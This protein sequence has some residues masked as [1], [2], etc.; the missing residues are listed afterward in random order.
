M[1]GADLHLQP[2]LGVGER[3]GHDP[4]VVD[5][6]VQRPVAPALG[7]GPDRLEAGEV[8]HRPR[9]LASIWALGDVG[10]GRLGQVGFADGD[11]H[12]GPGFGQGAGGLDPDAGGPAGDDGDLAGQVLAGDDVASVGV[13]P[14]GR[15]DAV[16]HDVSLPF[17][18]YRCVGRYSCRT[19][20]P[21]AIARHSGP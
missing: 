12:L 11:D 2:V 8:Q 21:K 6:Q 5:Q 3:A 7:E 9:H 15:G 19:K 16:G 4:G 1:V 13:G 14:E 20:I 17:D 10:D 18:F